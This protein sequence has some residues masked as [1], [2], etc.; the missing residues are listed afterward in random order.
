MRA[1]LAH[2][3]QLHSISSTLSEDNRKCTYLLI[4]ARLS[5]DQ[6]Y[7]YTIR[8]RATA[9]PPMQLV[10]MHIPK[11]VIEY[12]DRYLLGT[13]K[14]QIRIISSSTWRVHVRCIVDG[15]GACAPPLT[16]ETHRLAAAASARL[17]C[18]LCCQANADGSLLVRLASRWCDV[19]IIRCRWRVYGPAMYDTGPYQRL[20]VC[21]RYSGGGGRIQ[22]LIKVISHSTLARH[23]GTR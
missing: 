16:V 23:S 14:R 5:D 15:S 8:A 10:L 6:I 13:R 7:R 19:L 12:S 22:R 9:R 20:H 11:L 18:R 17:H 3:A 2:A 4:V 21:R 1:Q